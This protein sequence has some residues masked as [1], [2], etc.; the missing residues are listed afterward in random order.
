MNTIIGIDLGTSTTEAAVLQDG[1][2]VMLLNFDGKAETPSVVGLDG[3]GNIVVGEKAEG[4]ILLAPEQ[5]VKEVKRLMGTKEKVFLGKRACSPVEVSSM[6]LSY[7]RNFAG[8]Y[9]GE[10]VDRAVIS[11]PAYFDEI[12]RQAT[13]EAGRQAGFTV[14]RILNEP[15]A[16][17][18]SYGISHLEEESNILVYDLGGG[19]F[20]VTLLE[21]FE[22]VLEVR[23]SSGDNKLGG[24][25]F[26]GRLVKYLSECF[27]KKQG[28]SLEGDIYA[29]ARLHQAAVECKKALST[30]EEYRVLLPMIT[31]KEGVPVELDETVGR[32]HFEELIRDLVERTHE[33]IDVV[34][35]DS[36]MTAEDLDM[37]LLVGGSTRIPLVQTDIED[38][39][40][41]KPCF[42]VDPDY[43][44]AQGAAIQAGIINGLVDDEK[45]IMMTD[46]NPYTLGIRSLNEYMMDYMSVIIPRNVTIPVTKKQMY[47]TSWDGQTSADIEVYQG[48]SR[49]VEENHL[50]G[51]F[52]IHGIPTGPAGK[53]RLEVAFSYNQ[54]GM[55]NVTAK[56]MSTG[57]EASITIDM[58]Q[59]ADGEERMDVSGWKESV[60]AEDYRT[61]IRR[62]ERWL[63]KHEGET[64][65]EEEYEEIEE[66]LYRLKL[67]VIEEEDGDAEDLEEEIRELMEEYGNEK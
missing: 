51:T 28:I 26:D 49:S 6:I 21:L 52:R 4:Q 32:E 14:E 8:K 2:P 18:L 17:A 7:V 42:A 20:D 37:I 34:L 60:L 25:D 27:E 40:G 15:T 63:K 5:T 22:G 9:L 56:I 64:G 39:L 36:G 12:Q 31:E 35:D 16:A 29:M 11:V 13:V 23:A 30:Q 62:A 41:K 38:Y 19:T 48:E 24:K 1:K 45:G 65:T 55:L 57:K 61:V 50:I 3:T 44:V 53:E 67:A 33:P 66:L 10:D 43:A 46:V 59:T 54:N 58:M 47:Y